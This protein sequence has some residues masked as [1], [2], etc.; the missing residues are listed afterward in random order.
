MI[1]LWKL[2]LA[3]LVCVLTISNIAIAAPHKDGPREL[4]DHP[5]KGGVQGAVTKGSTAVVT[6]KITY[7]NGALISTP[8]IYYIWYGNWNQANGSDTPSGQQILRDFAN[9][10]GASPHFQINTTYSVTGK[11]ITGS[12]GFGGE[13]TDAYSRG[14]RLKDADVLTIVTSAI[15]SGRLPYDASG[16]YF[17]LSSTDVR[18]T[19]GFCTSYCGWHTA[20]TATVGRVRYSFVGNANR[21]L[22]GCA[23]QS[24]SPNG[25]AGVDGMASII[26]HEL[27]E[28][29]TDPDP[30]S[31]W[32]DSGGAENAD[33]CAWTFGQTLLT[34][35]NGSVY[36]MVLG[37]RQF[38]IQRNLKQNASGDTCNVDLTHQ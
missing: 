35:A 38:L 1:R 23:A 34:A 6:P 11:T 37:G 25:N 36:N 5:R 32:V 21:C 12:V 26:A 9:G 13:T 22:T 8:N 10:I 4:I 27:E 28:A 3:V 29:T 19:S 18:E 20:A 30:R 33:K 16:V 31:G 14:T 2:V 24:V 7:H 17:V 15:S